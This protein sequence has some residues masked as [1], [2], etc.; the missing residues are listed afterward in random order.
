MVILRRATAVGRMFIAFAALTSSVRSACTPI[1]GIGASNT[2]GVALCA[3]H[4]VGGF[5]FL[6][7]Q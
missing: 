3:R 7:E 6:E 4:P 2:F 5:V 1:N